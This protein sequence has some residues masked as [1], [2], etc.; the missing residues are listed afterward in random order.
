MFKRSVYITEMEDNASDQYDISN[1]ES[2]WAG[3]REISLHEFGDISVS[4]NFRG[5]SFKEI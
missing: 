2:A 3:Y 4:I 1:D 5:I